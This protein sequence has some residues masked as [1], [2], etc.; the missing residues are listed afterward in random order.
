[1]I[2]HP[3]PALSPARSPTTP[4][5]HRRTRRIIGILLIISGVLTLTYTAISFFMAAQLVYEPPKPILE[6]PADLGLSYR[7]VVFTSRD[8]HIRL[9]GWF[10]PGVLLD[11]RLTTE[12]TLIVVHGTRANRTDFGAGVLDLSGA[13]ARNGF[14]ILA[15][16]MRGQGESAPAPISF[17]LLEQRD[18][19]GAVDFLRQ[20]TVPYPE[21]GRPRVIGGWG[22]SMGGA[23]LVMAAA[24]EPAIKAI[25]G[26]S[27][28]TDFA[29]V[30]EREV[31]K[32]GGLPALF[33]PG[34]LLFGRTFYGVDYYAIRPVDY[35]ARIVPR[36]LFLIQGAS[37][38]TVPVTDLA[39][40]RKAASVPANA[41][42]TSW[43][44]PYAWHSQPYHVLEHVYV[45]RVVTFYTESLGLDSSQAQP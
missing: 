18:V 19:L 33:T 4:P 26:D 43:L 29:P 30:L 41:H 34:A 14:A 38:E 10:I 32:Q 5:S 35:I 17:G 8:D 24:R 6:T 15:F 1:M 37:D 9:N 40:L 21:L 25:V 44:V 20:G 23:A 27:V 3:P 22:L 13:F 12:R 2:T 45:E 11:G 28:F 42:V 39:A 16:D 7:N 36:P 31:P